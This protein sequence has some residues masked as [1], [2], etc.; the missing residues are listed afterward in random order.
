[1]KHQNPLFHLSKKAKKDKY[2]TLS[3]LLGGHGDHPTKL[4]NSHKC[5]DDSQWLMT[6][7]CFKHCSSMVKFFL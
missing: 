5:C 1:M 7:R 6:T 4:S 2:L 3:C